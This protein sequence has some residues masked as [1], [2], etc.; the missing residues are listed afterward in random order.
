MATKTRH[1]S[2]PV[3]QLDGLQLFGASCADIEE[4][5]D[6]VNE[7]RRLI[8]LDNSATTTFAQFYAT[9][10]E[11]RAECNRALQLNGVSADK[12]SLQ[13][14]QELLL[15]RKNDNGEVIPGLL[16]EINGCVPRQTDE[17]ASTIAA[18]YETLV[19]ALKSHTNSLQEAL[20]LTESLTPE[21]LTMLLT[22]HE[23]VAQQVALK[24]LSDKYLATTI[25]SSTLEEV[26]DNVWLT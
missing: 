20:D 8:S 1:K 19:Q 11:V 22:D 26:T 17:Q 23:K 16:I 5:V 4:F 7:L 6:C 24:K 14:L 18:N 2:R 3:A 10:A 12:I 9:S 25:D 13:T 15:F 21:Q